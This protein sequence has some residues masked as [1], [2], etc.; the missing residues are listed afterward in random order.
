M[1]HCIITNGA[2][3]TEKIRRPMQRCPLLG[4][5]ALSGQLEVT[6]PQLH[7]PKAEVCNQS[8]VHARGMLLSP[9]QRDTRRKCHCYIAQLCFVKNKWV[10]CLTPAS[11]TR[12]WALSCIS[13]FIYDFWW[14]PL[15][16]QPAKCVTLK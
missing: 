10:L 11:K 3:L 8:Q 7:F 15:I 9:Q 13:M 2:I 12:R 6:A 16:Q 14:W 4:S 5:G 1:H